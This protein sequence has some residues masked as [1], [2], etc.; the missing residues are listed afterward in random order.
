MKHPTIALSFS[1]V[2]V[3]AQSYLSSHCVA[4]VAI[5]KHRLKRGI[6]KV[7]RRVKKKLK[8]YLLC[9]AFYSFQEFFGNH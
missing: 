1:L 4:K 7:H 8:N 3:A 5:Q 9:K 6:D 2:S